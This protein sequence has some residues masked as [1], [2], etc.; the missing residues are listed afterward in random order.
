MLNRRMATIIIFSSL[1]TLLN[2]CAPQQ[3]DLSSLTC[4]EGE[5]CGSVDIN[6]ELESEAHDKPAGVPSLDAM[7]I[8]WE[9]SQ[10]I[11]QKTSAETPEF[12]IPAEYQHLDPQKIV[13][14]KAL[15]KAIEFHSKYKSKFKNQRFM[16]II[17]FTQKNTKKRFYIINL[18]TGVVETILVAHGKNSDK[19]FDGFATQFS[20]INGSLMS[21]LGAYMTAETYSGKHGYSLRLDGLEASNSLARQ[22][23]IVVHSADYVN[24]ARSPIGRSYGCPAIEPSLRTRIIDQI[25]GGSL[26][27]AA[28]I[29]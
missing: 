3:Q 5:N 19:D 17:D 16:S 2:A 28:F 4:A 6:S 21:S 15:L 13:P 26:I 25:K 7:N 1:A 29:Q 27:Y 10:K 8:Q 24:S 9:E 22:R 20:N 18:S 11:H 12:V 23:A 14:E